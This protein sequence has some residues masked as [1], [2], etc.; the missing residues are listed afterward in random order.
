MYTGEEAYRPR[1]PTTAN[2]TTSKQ[3]THGG[4]TTSCYTVVE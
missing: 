4:G 3:H 2:T 1:T